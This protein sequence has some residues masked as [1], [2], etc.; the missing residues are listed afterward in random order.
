M[1]TSGLDKQSQDFDHTHSLSTLQM[2][3]PTSSCLT[4]SADTEPVRKRTAT[5]FQSVAMKLLQALPSLL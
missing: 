4:L 2:T 3:P 5:I 1:S